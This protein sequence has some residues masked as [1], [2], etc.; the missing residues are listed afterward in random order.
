MALADPKAWELVQQ[1]MN[2]FQ[3]NILNRSTLLCS[4]ANNRLRIDNTTAVACIEKC[5]STKETLLGLTE[6]IF[7][8]AYERNVTLSAVHIPGIDNIDADRA[9]RDANIDTE[10]MIKPKI[11]ASLY[12]IFSK[13]S[14]DLFACR[15]NAQLPKYVSWRPDPNAYDTDAFTMPWT[16]DYFY[17]FPPFSVIG[18]SLQKIQ[19]EGASGL[20]VLPLWPTR[21]WFP[22][23]L[24]M[25]TATPRLL[26]QH[27]LTLPQDPQRQHPLSHKLILVAMEL[28]GDPWKTKFFRH[29]LPVF[30]CPLGDR[31]QKYNMGSISRNL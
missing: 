23:A 6:D 11:F 24:Q 21:T 26:P 8:W 30:S 22:R 20:M 15:I 13:P 18:R 1:A 27:S 14:I 19:Q 31:E 4:K 16:N 10:W 9:S 5:S 12:T 25:L 3:R 7:N 28:S 17:A 29:K 2:F